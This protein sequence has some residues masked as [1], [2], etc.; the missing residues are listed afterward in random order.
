MLKTKRRN[1]MSTAETMNSSPE[2]ATA[3]LEQLV[4]ST[5]NPRKTFDEEKLQEL[6]ESIRSKG[7]LSPL[8]VR[9]VNGH[10]EIVA[11][12]RRYRAAQRAGLSNVP[13]RIANLT[14]QEAREVQ[15]IE[16]LQRSDLHPFE[17]AQG[18]RALL[19][20]DTARYTIAKLSA[21]V[22]K[23][24]AYVAKR[25][26]LLDLTNTVAEAFRA[27]R[28]GIEHALLIAKLTPDVQENALTHCF[29]GYFA[30]NDS[31]RSLV[32]VSR[33]QAWIEQNIYLSLKSVPFSKDDQTLLPGAGSC[34]NCPKR[35][36]FNTLLFSEVRQ[37]ACSD[38]VCFNRKLEASIAQHK[39]KM[40]NVVLISERYDV[41]GETPILP[42]RQ[43][44]EVI[45]RKSK[46]GTEAQPEQRLCDHL[47]PAIYADGIDKGRLVKV[48]RDLSC[49]IHFGHQQE[50]E[51]QRL[52][53]KA[54]QTAAKRK[55]KRTISFRHHLLAEVLKRVK[56]QFECEDL[57]LVARFVLQSLPHELACRVAKRHGLQDPKDPRDWQIA[58]KARMLYKKADS[59]ELAS[60]I[61]E[62]MLIGPAASVTETKDDDLLA[63]AA[64]LCKIDVK[65]LR[66]RHAKAEEG[67]SQRKAEEATRKQKSSPKGKDRRK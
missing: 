67:K 38:A 49:K 33:L 56:P 10:L 48:C 64:A 66:A 22:A 20:G 29:D 54:E 19:D 59:A 27:G 55:A 11:G 41:P 32:P 15:T 9:P 39:E 24:A 35:T 37:D 23:P 17:E 46:K 47:T 51:K 5:T 36:G 26:K 31:E 21:R 45:A 42:R 57:R 7:I 58:E 65:A 25:L 61:F 44:V 12:A 16:N 43:Y 50:Q 8:V 3:L 34:T 13:V 60:L 1:A 4:E 63:D 28:I 2:Y 30:G 18:F 52:K 40:P 53:W 62:A 6:A 14:D